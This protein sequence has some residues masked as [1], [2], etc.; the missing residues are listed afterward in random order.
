MIKCPT[1]PTYK[2][3]KKPTYDVE[4]CWCYDIWEST[5][6]GVGL[7]IFTNPQGTFSYIIE[8]PLDA[9][10]GLWHWTNC[11]GK[12]ECTDSDKCS[13]ELCRT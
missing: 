5:Q 3:K 13:K 10:D 7:D 6:K 4:D 8:Y 9:H 11:S 12:K 1:H 2:G